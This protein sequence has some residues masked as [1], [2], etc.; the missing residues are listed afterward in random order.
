MDD[1]R[2]FRLA[3]LPGKLVLTPAQMTEQVGVIGDVLF[4]DA[5]RLV[6]GAL[7]VQ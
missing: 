6:A 5:I 1:Y 4:R 7:V 3:D 2:V